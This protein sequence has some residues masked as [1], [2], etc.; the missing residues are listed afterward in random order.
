MHLHCSM[1]ASLALLGRLRWLLIDRTDTE[2]KSERAKYVD[3]YCP[4]ETDLAAWKTRL[5]VIYYARLQSTYER[6]RVQSLTDSVRSDQPTL[7]LLSWCTTGRCRHSCRTGLPHWT[8]TLS[9][10][11]T[12]QW[13]AV[14]GSGGQGKAGA[15]Q[16]SAMQ[17]NTVGQ[18][19]LTRSR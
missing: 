2:P 10:H 5:V 13:R 1:W 8:A 17:C 11:Q 7:H 9:C 19:G 12:A 16:C 18:I 6:S 15:M 4:K 14:E 3:V